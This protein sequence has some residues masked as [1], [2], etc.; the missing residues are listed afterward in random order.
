[1]L[2]VIG[3]SRNCTVNQQWVLVWSLPALPRVHAM[4]RYNAE[5]ISL[6]SPRRM[7][8]MRTTPGARS[9]NDADGRGVESRAEGPC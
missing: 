8:L 4:A 1:M 2:D 6:I 9:I 5:S 3:Q 7:Y